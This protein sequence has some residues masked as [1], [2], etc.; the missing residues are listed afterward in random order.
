MNNS[1]SYV[2]SAI[3]DRAFQHNASASGGDWLNER[4]A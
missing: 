2:T 4:D 1:L 3:L